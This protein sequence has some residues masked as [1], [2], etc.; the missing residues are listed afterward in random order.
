MLPQNLTVLRTKA[1]ISQEELANLIGVSRQTYSVIERKVRKMA[2]S[3][4]LSLVLFYDNNRK[5]HKVIHQL[6][7]FT[8]ELF[9]RF[10]DRVDFFEYEL[11]SFIGDKS[12]EIIESL[13][14]RAK[15]AACAMVMMEYARCKI[16]N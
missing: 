6:F 14:E 7:I 8:K 5:K 11:S 10:N 15:G 4:Y 3:T 2:W 16:A 9:M 13:D 1:K 12:M